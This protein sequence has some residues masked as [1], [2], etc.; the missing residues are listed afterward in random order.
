MEHYG[1]CWKMTENEGKWV[2]HGWKTMRIHWFVWM[3]LGIFGQ[4]QRANFLWQISGQMMVNHQL[5]VLSIFHIFFIGMMIPNAG[6]RLLFVRTVI[7]FTGF[8][9]IFGRKTMVSSST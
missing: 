2:E 5:P 4:T 6:R 8:E 1:K 9:P 7:F 3:F